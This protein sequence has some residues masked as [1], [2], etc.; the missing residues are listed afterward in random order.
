[1][2]KT[3]RDLAVDPA[4]CDALEADGKSNPFPIQ[5]LTLPLALDGHDLIGQAR[6]GTGKTLAFGIPL[7]QRIDRDAAHTQALVIVP[8]RELC[9]QVYEDL[10]IGS[11]LG[12]TSI[13]VYGGVGYDEQIDALTKGA[14]VV[15]GTPGR[16]L[17]LFNRGV[18]DLSKVTQL[19]LD[20]ADEMLDM[21]FL[22]DVERLIEGCTGENRHTMLFSATMPTAI[23]KLARRYM[24]HPTFTRA[25]HEV[26]TTAD[27]VTQHFFQVHRMDKPRLLAR[28][29]QDENRGG[30]YVFV[31]TK[32]M[33]DRLVN[34]LEELRIPA[35]AIH[36]DLRQSTREKNLDRFRDGSATVLVCTEVAARGLDVSGVTHVVNYDCPDDEKMYLHRIGRTARAGEAGV[37]VT[38]AEFNEVDRLNVIRKKVEATDAEVHQVF[39][40][41]PVLEELF[42]LPAEKPWEHLT[43]GSSSGSRSGGGKRSGGQRSSG[44]ER[45]GG[46]KRS[47]SGDGRD[48]RRGGGSGG[49]REATATEERSGS[50]DGGDRG[51]GSSSRGSDRP[52]SSSDGRPKNRRDSEGRGGRHDAAPDDRSRGRDRDAEPAKSDATTSRGEDRTRSDQRDQG[53]DATTPT[54]RTRTRTR[55]RARGGEGAGSSERSSTRSSQSSGSRSSERS[56][57]RG[58]QGSERDAS[59]RDRDTGRRDDG[60]RDAGRDTKTSSSGRTRARGGRRAQGGGSRSGGD[61]DSGS[62]GGGGR[63]GDGGGGERSGGRDR[64]RDG[65]RGDSSDGGSSGRG[66]SSARA[67][68]DDRDGRQSSGGRNSRNRGGNSR[69]GSNRGGSSRGGSNRGGSSRGGSNR[70]GSSRGGGRPEGQNRGGDGRDQGAQRSGGRE[71]RDPTVR[72]AAR[73]EEARG[74]GEPHLARRVKVE[75]L[76]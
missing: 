15:V 71:D 19:V 29:L 49:A 58:E 39:S 53:D 27:N 1:M 74:E 76:P 67:G 43:T 69:G 72:H 45:S 11:V 6:T 10:S 20:E 73:G 37:A 21:G 8:T 44:G 62:S 56:G 48:G 23:V 46:G 7:L 32:H 33:A 4:L 35:I 54:T 55:T 36:G 70:G 24:D 14:H 61:A 42:T 75:H 60:D 2:T 52:R 28:V 59:G 18:L 51:R 16:L 31:R 12:L 3:F 47:G 17:D 65:G 50:K 26:K 66:D 38:F 68:A 22:P 5:E 30:V 64:S 25:D 34:D 40:T 13:S 41:S 9:L 57:G 63:G